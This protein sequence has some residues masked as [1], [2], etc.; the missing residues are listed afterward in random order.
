MVGFKTTFDTVQYKNPVAHFGFEA[1]T[2]SNKNLH[3]PLTT[4]DACI[5]VKSI[6]KLSTISTIMYTLLCQ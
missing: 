1:S 2:T 3:A 5:S 4:S 6:H